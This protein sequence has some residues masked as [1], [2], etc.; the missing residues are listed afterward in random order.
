[1]LSDSFLYLLVE[2]V[3]TAGKTSRPAATIVGAAVRL[4]IR[5]AVTP[6][7]SF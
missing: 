3:R 1:M 4:L 5:R 2:M 6:A 7:E